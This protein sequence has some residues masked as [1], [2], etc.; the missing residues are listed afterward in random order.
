[1]PPGRA[2]RRL[3]RGVHSFEEGCLVGG[4]KDRCGVLVARRRWL[5]RLRSSVR[6]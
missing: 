3:A 1:M 5:A 6:R 4:V 2:K